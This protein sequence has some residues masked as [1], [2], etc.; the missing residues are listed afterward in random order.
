MMK[1]EVLFDIFSNIFKIFGFWPNNSMSRIQKIFLFGNFVIFVINSIILIGLTLLDVKKIGDVVITLFYLIGYCYVVSNIF[2]IWYHRDKLQNLMLNIRE[3]FY[4]DN[5]VLPFVFVSIKRAFLMT[6][7]MMTW[8]AFVLNFGIILTP[9]I[10]KFLPIPMWMPE[11]LDKD[12]AFGVYW[13]FQI[14]SVN[15]T[16]A[17]V[18]I[19]VFMCVLLLLINGYAEYLSF[20]L[21]TLVS[22]SN[23]SGYLELVECV[24]IHRKLKG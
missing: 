23:Y 16:L 7:V 24:Q 20:K 4:E 2:V 11:F 19:F 14:I 21:R 22:Y 5:L 15:Y 6:K 1:V 12:L 3:N 8:T 18:A 17:N 9:S 10:L 13:A